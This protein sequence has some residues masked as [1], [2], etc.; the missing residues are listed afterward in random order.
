MSSEKV[1]H[2]TDASFEEE[3]INSKE[4][5]LVDFWADWCFPCKSL[6]PVVDEIAEDYEGRLK[7]VKLDVDQNPATPLKYGIRSIPSLL[8]F[9]DGQN[10]NMMIGSVPKPKLAAFIDENM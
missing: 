1:T 2:V 6:S 10:V 7:V 3:V 4:P 9:K 8:I 5:V